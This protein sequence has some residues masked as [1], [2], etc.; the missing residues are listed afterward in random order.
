MGNS[1]PV[2]G[3]RRAISIAGM[4]L[5]EKRNRLDPEILHELL[6]CSENLDFVRSEAVIQ[7]SNAAAAGSSSNSSAAAV[8]V[9]VN[10]AERSSSSSAAAVVVKVNNAESSS[11]SS[12]AAEVKSSTETAVRAECADDA[13][14]RTEKRKNKKRPRLSGNK[15]GVISVHH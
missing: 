6:L 8:V 9:K 2:V 3:G 13:A 12:A 5:A 7:S 4:I 15:P 11:S 14:H 1:A 10:N